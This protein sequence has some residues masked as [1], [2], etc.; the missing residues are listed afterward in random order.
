V[1]KSLVKLSPR[2]D[3]INVLVTA[4]MHAA[5][6]KVHPWIQSHLAFFYLIELS[7]I[8]A[9]NLGYLILGTIFL[10]IKLISDKFDG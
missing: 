2:V 10:T 5:L 3:F 9:V 7:S 8:F 6:Q 4:F 1:R